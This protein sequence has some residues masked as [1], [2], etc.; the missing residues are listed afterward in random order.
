V[1]R[2]ARQGAE[3]PDIERQGRIWVKN[4]GHRECEDIEMSRYTK[5]SKIERY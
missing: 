1:G 5:E 3:G 2:T 4:K